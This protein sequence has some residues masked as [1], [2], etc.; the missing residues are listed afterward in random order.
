VEERKEEVRLARKFMDIEAT[1]ASVQGDW[2]AKTAQGWL[3][4]KVYQ[5]DRSI[6]ASTTKKRRM[7]YF[8][9]HPNEDILSQP[10]LLFT[11]PICYP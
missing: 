10:S 6:F 8:S 1:C 11:R 5:S 7:F 4:W 9:F 3:L 2:R